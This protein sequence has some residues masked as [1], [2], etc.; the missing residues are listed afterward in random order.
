MRI[1]V[2]FVS[3][4]TV[5]IIGLLGQFWISNRK[6]IPT[7]REERAKVYGDFL[8]ASLTGIRTGI[9]MRDIYEERKG[10]SSTLSREEQALKDYILSEQ[11]S[12]DTQLSATLAR[13]QIVSPI[14][15]SKVGDQLTKTIRAYAHNEKT[16]EEMTAAYGLF[17][18]TARE[19][20]DSLN[21]QSVSLRSILS[22]KINEI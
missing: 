19:D 18:E 4:I 8:S 10:K 12:Y 22:N 9:L 21:K 6:F 11:D 13:M 15:I 17:T 5:A 16:E 3:A 20:L 14:K 7:I 1:S 2:T